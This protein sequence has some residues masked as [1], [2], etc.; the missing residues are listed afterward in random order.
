MIKHLAAAALLTLC[1]S[2]SHADGFDISRFSNT[3]QLVW[4]ASFREHVKT[5]FGSDRTLLFYEGSTVE[6]VLSGL[7]G[8]PD[9]I[10]LVAP[11]TYLAT[12]CRA[13]SCSEKVAYA[14]N[15]EEEI[16]GVIGYSCNDQTNEFTYCPE[17]SIT[18]FYKNTSSKDVLANIILSWAKPK[19][20]Q[21]KIRMI[22][23]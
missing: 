22:K 14:A 18:L 20:P 1:Q 11:N 4:D 21:A 8:P 16:F 10:K 19:A 6:Q 5:Y 13:Q 9:S 7:G 17:G 23:L 12:A 15:G 2:V 3:N